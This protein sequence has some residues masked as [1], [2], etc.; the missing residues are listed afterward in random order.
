M[1]VCTAMTDND[2]NLAQHC[3]DVAVES[4]HPPWV[5]DQR[6]ERAADHDHQLSRVI[7]RFVMS[8]PA[9]PRGT[10]LHQIDWE[11]LAADRTLAAFWGALDDDGWREEM[12][13][14]R[15]CQRG[16]A[17]S[18]SSGRGISTEMYAISKLLSFWRHWG[19]VLIQSTVAATTPLAH[20]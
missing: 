4:Q 20:S 17:G 14:I 11:R 19:G 16:G 18:L 7:S 2:W 13:R 1:D 5:A 8:T 12:A 6:A 9:K 10:L 3:R 15:D